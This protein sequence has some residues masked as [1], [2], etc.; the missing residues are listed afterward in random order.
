MAQPDLAP[1][2][3]IVLSLS[4]QAQ[5][6]V[7]TPRRLELVRTLRS[8]EITSVSELARAVRRSIESV[9]RDL[10]VLRSVGLIEFSRDGT[11]KR[12][13]LAK[14]VIVMPIA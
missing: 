6:R 13:I 14:D 5:H 3:L 11:T 10:R 4:E 9:S 8:K 2:R 12:P 1:D 7:L